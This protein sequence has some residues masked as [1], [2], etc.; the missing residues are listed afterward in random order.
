MVEQ[1]KTRYGVAF[2]VGSPAFLLPG[3]KEVGSGCRQALWFAQ[4]AAEQEKEHVVQQL[5]YSG[6]V[7]CLCT[8]PGNLRVRRLNQYAGLQDTSPSSLERHSKLVRS[9]DVLDQL[10][11]RITGLHCVIMP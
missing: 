4:R 2:S 5:Q 3:L 6:A 10:T 9:E 1:L 11:Q 7:S 8:S